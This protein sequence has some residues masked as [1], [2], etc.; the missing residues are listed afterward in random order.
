MTMLTRLRRVPVVAY[1]FLAF[2]IVGAIAELGYHFLPP[3]AFPAY[4]RWL[5]GLSPVD[6]D[7]FG[8]AFELTAHIGIAIGLMGMVAT[9][10]Y[11]QLGKPES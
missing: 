11:Q 4:S 10:V 5:A 2:T 6:R 7:F 8:L 1:V 9:L 3:Q